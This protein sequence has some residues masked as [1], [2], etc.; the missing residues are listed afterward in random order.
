MIGTAVLD[1]GALTPF[2]IRRRAEGGIAVRTIII[3]S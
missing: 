1:W 2:L 3:T